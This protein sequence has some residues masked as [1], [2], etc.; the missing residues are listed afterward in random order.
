[1]MNAPLDGGA[2][3]RSQ[4]IEDD[5]HG[6]D[7]PASKPADN[8]GVNK[9]RPTNC[10]FNSADA[11]TATEIQRQISH[12]VWRRDNRLGRDAE[13]DACRWLV[14]HGY[15]GQLHIVDSQTGK[16]R[17]T[18]NIEKAARLTVKEGPHGPYF[19]KWEPSERLIVKG[20][21]Q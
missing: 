18:I 2:F 14:R 3:R 21:K 17:S 4:K 19:A 7:V 6:V 15:R 16:H 12:S 5:R 9:P 11:S 13:L 20:G 8:F 1:M 10:N